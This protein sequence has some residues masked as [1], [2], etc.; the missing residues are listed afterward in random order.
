MENEEKRIIE[1]FSFKCFVTLQTNLAF[2]LMLICYFL[3]FLAFLLKPFSV[4]QLR[5]CSYLLENC[6][7]QMQITTGRYHTLLIKDS[8]VYSC[9]SSLCG[10]LG[11]GPETT[12]CVAF[13][14]INFPPSAQVTQ[15]SASYNHVAFVMQSG[16][17]CALS[18][19]NHVFRK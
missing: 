7:L 5:R 19:S 8:S 4:V 6:I 11:H 2:V 15:V 1:L 3:Q 12:Q 13:S 17:V 16:E 9:G 10:A 18:N 14:R